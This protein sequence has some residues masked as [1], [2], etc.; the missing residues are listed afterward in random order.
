MRLA[1]ADLY[2][3][4]WSNEIH[5]EWTRN[6]AA[7]RPDIS[8]KSLARCRKLKD[9]HSPDSLVTGYEPLIT[10]LS[11]LDPGDRHVLAAAIHGGVKLIVTFNLASTSFG[12]HG[13]HSH[14]GIVIIWLFALSPPPPLR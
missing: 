12:R 13:N 8:P 4:R 2:Q 5:D 10:S 11:L 7:D 14:E 3:A 6:V 9:A 1:L